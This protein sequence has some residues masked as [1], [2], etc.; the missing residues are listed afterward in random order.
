M[1]QSN[2]LPSD[3]HFGTIQIGGQASSYIPFHNP[4]DKPVWVQL[5]P[6]EQ[7]A[8]M[9]SGEGDDQAKKEDLEASHV[10]HFE[11]EALEVTVLRS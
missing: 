5:V 4:A 1:K 10:Y 8:A 9:E 11:P 3:I 7:K 2:P 6:P